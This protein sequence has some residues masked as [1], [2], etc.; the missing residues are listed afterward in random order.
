[1]GRSESKDAYNTEKQMGQQNQ[2]N[3]QAS[4]AAE[5]AAVGKF[6]KSIDDYGNF[7]GNEFSPGGDFDKTTTAQASSVAAGGKNSL[8]DFYNNYGLRTG[9]GT[10]PQMIAAS[11]ESGRQ[12][13][14]DLSNLLNQD[15]LARIGALG[16]GKETMMQEEGQIPGIYGSQYG[17]SLGGATSAMGGAVDAA[18]TPGFWDTFLPALA[19]GAGAAAGGFFEGQGKKGG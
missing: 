3:A 6:Q 2:A 10:T 15:T 11:E 13:E 19:G 7:I 17:T 1:M 18:K 8:E 16:H 9:S 5:N 14:R 12:S 4:L